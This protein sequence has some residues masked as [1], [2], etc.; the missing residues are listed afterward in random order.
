MSNCDFWFEYNIEYD[1]EIFEKNGYGIDAREYVASHLNCSQKNLNSV[2]KSTEE[3]EFM[4][5]AEWA[6]SSCYYMNQFLWDFLYD[7]I[8]EIAKK[9]TNKKIKNHGG[10]FEEIYEE[11]FNSIE[12][13]F[14]KVE[15]CINKNEYVWNSSD[16]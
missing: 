2:L 11:V 7:R 14:T 3:K 9:I 10:I 16:C 15:L 8:E 4:M 5:I 13:K 6:G 1:N 12:Y